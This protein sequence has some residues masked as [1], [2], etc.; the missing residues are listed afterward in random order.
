MLDK[1]I[2]EGTHAAAAPGAS[3][4]RARV[5][6]FFF[7]AA[8]RLSGARFLLGG[9]GWH[10]KAAPENLLRLGHVPTRDHNAFNTTPLAVLNV[11]RDSMAAVGFSPATRVFEAAGA[12]ACLISDAWEGIELFLAPDEEILVARDGAEVVE[13]LRGLTR[14]RAVAIGAARSPSTPMIGALSRSSNRSRRR[15]PPGRWR[16]ASRRPRAHAQLVLGERARD[17]MARIVAGLCGRGRAASPSL[18]ATCAGRRRIATCPPPISPGSSS[19]RNSPICAPA[20]PEWFARR[21]RCYRLVCPQGRGRNRLGIRDS[22]RTFR[23]HGQC[24]QLRL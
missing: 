11:A 18:S 21:T 16:D 9:N 19:T 6:A 2:L 17:H 12:G 15:C 1:E 3:T 23:L 24:R 7:E 5:H 20:I 14:E 22:A 10:G 4:R 8:R 13:Y